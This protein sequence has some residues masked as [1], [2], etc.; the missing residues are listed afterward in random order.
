[1][2]F[3]VNIGTKHGFKEFFKINSLNYKPYIIGFKDSDYEDCKIYSIQE[4]R[5]GTGLPPYFNK[6]EDVINAYTFMI[7]RTYPTIY[8]K[9]IRIGGLDIYDCRFQE[10]IYKRLNNSQDECLGRTGSSELPEGLIDT[11]KIVFGVPFA[12]SPPHFYG[13]KGVWNNYIR[14]LNGSDEEHG[15]FMHYEPVSGIPL[16]LSASLQVNLVLPHFRF[17]TKINLLSGKI[18]PVAW[19]NYVSKNI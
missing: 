9:D 14:G 13:Y 3:N 2:R 6:D 11:S 8:S 15:S 1:M 16:T 18:I 10:G 19:L 12:L 7:P 17:G 5:D 4:G